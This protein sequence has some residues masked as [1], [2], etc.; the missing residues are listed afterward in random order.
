M[1]EDRVAIRLTEELKKKIAIAALKKGLKMSA[2]IR[3][4]VIASIEDA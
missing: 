4:V 3:M 2:Y 1:V